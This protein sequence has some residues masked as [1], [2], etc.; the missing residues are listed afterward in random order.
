[1]KKVIER[2]VKSPGSPGTNDLW[3]TEDNELKVYDNEEWKT[4]AGGSDSGGGDAPSADITPAQGFTAFFDLKHNRYYDKTIETSLPDAFLI[5]TGYL[6]NLDYAQLEEPITF[7]EDNVIDLA[8]VIDEQN[9]SIKAFDEFSEFGFDVIEPL[10]TE[11]WGTL[12]SISVIFLWSIEK[13]NEAIPQMNTIGLKCSSRSYEY[14]II[15][16]NT[17]ANPEGSAW[18]PIVLKH[19]DKLYFSYSYVGD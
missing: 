1:M 7:N 2:I 5:S 17:F 3:L 19:G 6:Y 8:Y 9:T 16:T 15:L 4:I 18:L 12:S 13:K 10:L 14:N 11:T